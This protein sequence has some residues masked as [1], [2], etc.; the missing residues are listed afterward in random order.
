MT[1]TIPGRSQTYVDDVIAEALKVAAKTLAAKGHP[2]ANWLWQLT[3]PLP[4]PGA[5]T[6]VADTYKLN[7]NLIRYDGEKPIAGWCET[8]F[9]RQLLEAEHTRRVV[10][11]IGDDVAFALLNTI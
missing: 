8:C 10:E 5:P 2:T 7:V 4:W 11:L 6:T 1:P 9:K 3:A